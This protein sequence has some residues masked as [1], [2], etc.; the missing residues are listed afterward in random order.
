MGVVGGY[1]RGGVYQV[2]FGLRPSATAINHEWEEVSKWA[3]GLAVVSGRGFV[4]VVQEK[5][6]V[7]VDINMNEAFLFDRSLIQCH[8][9]RIF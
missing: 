8:L 5:G 6:M 7:L 9:T 1:G 3:V 2:L 4:A